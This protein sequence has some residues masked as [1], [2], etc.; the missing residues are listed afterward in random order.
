MESLRSIFYKFLLKKIEFLHSTL[1]RLW[2]IRQSTFVIYLA[3]V[4]F[5][6]ELAAF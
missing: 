4:S 6:T 5:S 3:G 2:R 1:V